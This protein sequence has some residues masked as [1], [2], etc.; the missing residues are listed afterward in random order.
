[1]IFSTTSAKRAVIARKYSSTRSTVLLRKYWKAQ[2]P[3][4]REEQ[5]K[6]NAQR[7]ALSRA[8]IKNDP[9]NQQIYLKKEHS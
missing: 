7:K 6:S 4:K 2:T 5:L 1:M 8:M 9:M 3:K